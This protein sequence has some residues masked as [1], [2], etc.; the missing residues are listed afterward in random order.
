MSEVHTKGH[1]KKK[2]K[3]KAKKK[4]DV[5]KKKRKSK[6][7]K[8]IKKKKKLV[9]GH[10]KNKKR[11]KGKKKKRTIA[12][13]IGLAFIISIVAYSVVFSLFF[14]VGK[15]DGYSMMPTVNNQDKVAV[16][17]SGKIKRFDLVYMKTPGGHKGSSVRRVIGVPGDKISFKDDELF[18]NGEGKNEKYLSGKKKMM[19][20]MILTDDFTL[21][22]VTGKSE[23]PKDCY[24][25]LG[26]NRKSSTDS[27]FYGFVSKDEVIGK[28]Q[29]RILPVSKF[30]VF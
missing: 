26:D 1:K 13:R 7:R 19:K 3:P 10:K 14:S 9:Y 20:S 18:I 23:V 4:S 2:N 21:D 25:V 5:L 29:V 12:Y 27:R 30:K 24:F 22:E 16:S 6:K 11:K 8:N 28:V 15:M 17:R